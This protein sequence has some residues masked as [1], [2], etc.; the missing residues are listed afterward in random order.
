MVPLTLLQ[1]LAC[2]QQPCCCRYLDSKALE[3][4]A[5]ASFSVTV[6]SIGVLVSAALYQV[7]RRRRRLIATLTVWI[8]LPNLSLTMV[9]SLGRTANTVAN[10]TAVLLCVLVIG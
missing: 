5:V 2:S 8:L 6:L 3:Q 9:A 7:V 4:D 10:T 1:L